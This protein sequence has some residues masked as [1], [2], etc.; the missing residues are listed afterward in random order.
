[1][2]H[3]GCLKCRI[4]NTGIKFSRLRFHGAE[5]EGQD[6]TEDPGGEGSTPTTTPEP[7]MFPRP[8]VEELRNESASYRTKLREAEAR[9]AELDA[10][11]KEFEGEK[12]SEIERAQKERDEAAAARDAAL[13]E[14]RQI[15]M[16]RMVSKIA[17]NLNFNDPDD[18]LALLPPLEPGDD[19]LPS[20]QAVRGA[21]STI[22]KN[23]PIW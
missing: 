15:R 2:R 23:K 3:F 1:M 12:L 10:K 7:D 22:A 4:Q 9:L 13:A 20:E 19:G 8:Y 18:A 16:E 11:V 6:P 5:G 21:L 14:A 17:A